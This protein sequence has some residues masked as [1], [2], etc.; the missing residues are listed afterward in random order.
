MRYGLSRDAHF[1]QLRVSSTFADTPSGVD[2]QRRLVPSMLGKPSRVAFNRVSC[3]RLGD[4]TIAISSGAGPFDPRFRLLTMSTYD[5]RQWGYDGTNST[6]EGFYWSQSGAAFFSVLLVV[7]WNY[8]IFLNEVRGRRGC[9]TMACCFSC[10]SGFCSCFWLAKET[11]P[12]G[13]NGSVV[14]LRWVG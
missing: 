7:H 12:W 1:A 3:C 8:A 5:Y 4:P 13:K 2:V 9:T 10:S 6:W 11:R 14:V